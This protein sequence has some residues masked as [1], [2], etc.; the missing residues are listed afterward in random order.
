MFVLF[1]S[2][3]VLDAWDQMFYIPLI[4]NSIGADSVLNCQRTSLSQQS[5]FL[6]G[7]RT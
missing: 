3:D 7:L 4:I 2:P 6:S 5:R 1:F